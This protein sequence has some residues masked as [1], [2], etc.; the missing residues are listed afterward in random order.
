[1]Y[2]YL[3]RKWLRNVHSKIWLAGNLVLYSLRSCPPISLTRRILELG[4]MRLHQREFLSHTHIIL[5]TSPAMNQWIDKGSDKKCSSVLHLF[6]NY[7]NPNFKFTI[8]NMWRF[9]YCYLVCSIQ[10]W[11]RHNRWIQSML[12]LFFTNHDPRC[13]LSI[14]NQIQWNAIFSLIHFVSF[15]ISNHR[16]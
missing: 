4:A 1:M 10:V 12:N 16:I 2:L 6:Q 13:C 3:W 11:I 15:Q 14:L 5:R 7:Q 9:D 8:N